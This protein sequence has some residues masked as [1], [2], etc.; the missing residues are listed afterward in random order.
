MK[1]FYFVVNN[2]N[3]HIADNNNKIR[4]IRVR[5]KENYSRG[6]DEDNTSIRPAF[7]EVSAWGIH[8]GKRGSGV[9]GR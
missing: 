7:W 9:L 2:L 1:R 6:N 3:R 5:D 8:A 4:I